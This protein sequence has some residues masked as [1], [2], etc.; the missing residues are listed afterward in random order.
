MSEYVERDGW[1]EW[2]KHTLLALERL[3]KQLE[4]MRQDI[5]KTNVDVAKLNFISTHLDEINSKLHNLKK[6]IAS[7]DDDFKEAVTSLEN[8]DKANMKRVEDHLAGI[9]KKLD[10]LQEFMQ[11][12]KTI[13]WVV[14]SIVAALVGMF[15]MSLKD[16]LK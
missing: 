7:K 15:S 13:A 16:L 5:V 3:D 9:T 14:G 4:V 8:D 2:S 12:T 11:K 10:E 1:K 6:D